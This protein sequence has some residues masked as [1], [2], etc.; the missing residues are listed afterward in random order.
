MG[1]EAPR[2]RV[3]VAVIGGGVQG[4]ASAWRLAEAGAGRV[5][6]LE[7][8]PL[9]HARGGSGGPT[10]IFRVT[11]AD[12]RYGDLARATR[13][14]WPELEA[15]AGEPLLAPTP[16]TLF[17]PPDGLMEVYRREILGAPDVGRIDPASAAG[18]FPTLRFDAGDTILEERGAAVIA[19]DRTVRALARLGRARGV[20]LLE[21]TRVDSLEAGDDGLLLATSVGPVLAARVV[22]ASGAWSARLIPALARRL[23]CVRQTVAYLRRSDTR[24]PNPIWIR[25]GE[26][27]N[28]VHYGLPTDRP[29]VFK[30]ARHVTV[31]SGDD[32]DATPSAPDAAAVDDLRRHAAR[33]VSGA[34]DE[35][36]DWD[37]CL[38]TMTAD[39][40]FVVGSSPSDERI[41]VATGF[42]GHGFK[43]APVIGRAVAELVERGRLASA[44]FEALAASWRP[45]AS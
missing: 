42:S 17:G 39:E 37:T 23:V 12:R 4:L 2:R 32:P 28:E 5:L 13:A 9:G 30:I 43:F 16:C 29:D 38:Y 8:G 34:S 6:V 33:C 19:A 22:V 27:A 26:R 36:V 41:V 11:Y 15:A 20:E 35:L 10:R 40:H 21:R 45:P 14:A 44:E 24:H 7:Q 1:R 18:R 25:L 3:D 31:G